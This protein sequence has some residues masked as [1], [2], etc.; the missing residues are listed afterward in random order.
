MLGYASHIAKIVFFWRVTIGSSFSAFVE[1]VA[2]WSVL[3]PAKFIFLQLA[4]MLTK[5][6]KYSCVSAQYVPTTCRLNKQDQKI[7][8][9]INS[10]LLAEKKIIVAHL[11]V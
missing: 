4:T 7:I 11:K 3:V 2:H 1:L 6:S 10:H 9:D 5:L 8:F